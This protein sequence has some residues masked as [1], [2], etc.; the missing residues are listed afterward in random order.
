MLGL[1]RPSASC[2][3]LWR[4]RGSP[5]TLAFVAQLQQKIT[6]KLNNYRSR[7]E[8]ACLSQMTNN[9]EIEK[10]QLETRANLMASKLK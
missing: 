2:V 1:Q 9:L 3:R 6:G 10:S 5:T 7:E 8:I 4:C